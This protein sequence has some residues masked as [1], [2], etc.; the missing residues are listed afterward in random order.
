M[1]RF[2]AIQN[3]IALKHQ[4]DGEDD[5]SRR[6]IIERLIEDEEAML[7]LNPHKLSGNV[8]FLSPSPDVCGGSTPRLTPSNGLP[9][10]DAAA[11]APEFDHR[12]CPGCD[13][14]MRL[15][16]IQPRELHRDDGYDVHQYRCE[17]CR[18]ESRFVLGRNSRDGVAGSAILKSP[19]KGRDPITAR[20]ALPATRRLLRGT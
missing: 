3:I 17:A 9:W 14:A 1:K 18:N 16:Y 13:A 11:T 7:L 19:A 10:H 8:P 4:L 15:V 2:L 5:P 12:R 6:S 20:R